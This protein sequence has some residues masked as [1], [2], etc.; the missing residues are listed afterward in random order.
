MRSAGR[1]L[2]EGA[3]PR[4]DLTL[5]IIG[6]D[7]RRV[8]TAQTFVGRRRIARVAA[9]PTMQVIRRPRVR[10][11]RR[12][13]LRVRADLRDGRRLTLDRRLRGCA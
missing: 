13:L 11:G 6:R 2:R 12:Y 7:R 8:T 5:R 9:A 4:G 10:T 3:C 1:A